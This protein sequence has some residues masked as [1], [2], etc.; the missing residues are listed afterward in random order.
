V[1]E[2]RR[3][4]G[5]L[6]ATMINAGTMI[7]SAIF[8][9]P[10]AVAA[11]LPNPL[12]MLAAWVVGGAVSLLG[13]LCVAELGAALPQ[14]GGQF[15]YLERAYGPVWGFLYA[16]TAAL[17]INPA[18]I[19]AIAVG[20]AT[21]V[22]F[23]VP[24]G[25]VGVKLVATGSILALTALNT[26]GL[27]LGAVVQN[28]LTLIKIG[29]LAALVLAVLVLPGGSAEHFR[30]FWPTGSISAF[31][32]P[33]GVAMV[34]VMWAYDG[35]IEI[36]Y[37]GS[38]VRDAGR[39]IPRSIALSMALVIGLYLVASAAY[40]YVLAPGRMA[41]ATL[42]ASDAAQVV[43]GSAGAAL[44]AGAIMVSTLGANNGIVL[45]SARIPY[46]VSRAGL[47]FRRMGAVHPRFHTPHIAL[48]VQGAVT[49]A[50]ALTG[51][52]DQLF[53]YVIFGE[54]LFFGMSAAAVMR[55]RATQPSLERPYRVWGYP[56]T[57][58]VFIA[59]TLWLVGSTLW[60][61][62][63]ESAIGGAII[64]AGVPVYRYWRGRQRE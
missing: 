13:A 9:V 59:F 37:V 11:A 26:L 47:F 52:Y 7:A 62:P 61:S 17:I 21:Y 28:V 57:P 25:G 20:F 64:L 29:A 4:L 19:A 53:T 34:A 3:E 6:D 14:A 51:T 32:G 27:R 44:V 43:M 56:A 10:A 30:P 8:I 33:F 23:F 12:A 18:S 16:W 35:W 46:A 48:L 31:L 49:A 15:V 41:G 40:L 1:S 42:V 50:F 58:L 60:Q 38:E 63:R 36:T 5:L 39:T 55:L 22:G 45:T 24:L 2:L 54:W